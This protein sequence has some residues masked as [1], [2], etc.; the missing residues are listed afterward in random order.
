MLQLV[1]RLCR[2]KFE[3]DPQA[4]EVR[5]PRCSGKVSPDQLRSAQAGAPAAMPPQT[6]ACTRCLRILRVSGASPTCPYCGEGID[7]AEGERLAAILGGLEGRVRDRLLAGD[8]ASAIVADLTESGI[9]SERA[10]TFLDRH[11]GELPFERHKAWKEGA[12]VRPPSACDSCGME[13]FGGGLVAHEAIWNVTKEELQ[14]YRSGWG[15]FEGDFEKRGNFTRPALYFLCPK[16]IK[17]AKSPDFADGYPYRF[18]FRM[19]R[20]GKAKV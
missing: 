15:G 4:V 6:L 3:A 7:A 2:A 16:C 11:L 12:P 17:S 14:R 13:A 9:D 1:C 5:C 10:W 20:F 19:E 8:T 18:G